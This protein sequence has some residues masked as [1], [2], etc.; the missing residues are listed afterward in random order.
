MNR[1]R[2]FKNRI[3]SW[4]MNLLIG[5]LMTFFILTSNII[6]S[7]NVYFFVPEANIR[8]YALLK[9]TFAEYLTK[10]GKYNVQPVSDEKIFE[11]FVKEDPDGVFIVSSWLFKKLAPANNLAAKL[12]MIVNSSNTTKEILLTKQVNDLA[13]IL[14]GG[15][16]SSSRGKVYVRDLL[17]TLLPEEDPTKVKLITVPRDMDALMSVG[18]GMANA[19][20]TSEDSFDKLAGINPYQHKEL[21]QLATSQEMLRPVV[22][23]NAISTEDPS[24][25]LHILKEISDD[26]ASKLLLQIVGVDGFAPVSEDEIGYV[27]KRKGMGKTE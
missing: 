16:V 13:M 9:N 12:T 25:F 3:Y 2:F 27:K 8:N 22:A 23:I 6:A 10:F 24:N 20:I 4:H 26:P 7:T 19:C 14:K 11:K 15:T 18:F 17:K 5:L 21:K 1:N